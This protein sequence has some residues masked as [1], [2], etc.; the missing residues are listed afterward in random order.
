MPEAP[1][2]LADWKPYPHQ[3]KL[4]N[5]LAGGGKTAVVVWHRRAGKDMVSLRWIV[6]CCLKDPGLYWYVFPTYDQAKS[7]IWQGVTRDG[8]AYLSFLPKKYILKITQGDLTIRFKNGSILKFVGA[9]RPDTLRGVEIKG[10]VISE[11]AVCNE[12]VMSSVIMPML[13]V[14]KGWIVYLY[15]P[16]SNPELAHGRTL[17]ERL[18]TN[19]K[20]FAQLLTI[21][22]T[23]DHDGNR[24]VTKQEL[25][26]S[27]KDMEEIAREFYCDFDAWKF[28]KIENSTFGD[29]LRT[30]EHEGRITHVPYDPSLTVN[31]YWDVGIVDY[32]TIFFVQEH[33]EFLHI[34]DFYV[35]R[36][37]DFRHYIEELKLRPYKYGKN[38]LPHDMG[39]RQ[40]P[41]LD[42][43]LQGANEI[44][45]ELSL[46][47]FSLGRMYHREE[48][49]SKAREIIKICKFDV[50]KCATAIDGLKGY[51]ASERKTYTASKYATD[52][53]DAFCYLAMDAKTKIQLDKQIDIY[54]YRNRNI[55]DNYNPLSYNEDNFNPY[56]NK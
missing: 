26:D 31:T 14:S 5:Y 7:A 20:A 17:Y 50:S 11:Y 21:E 8:K 9:S 30:A 28:R 38:V 34:I 36:G 1:T 52:I 44:A 23:E 43:R 37:K 45:K 49:V 56:E 42:T 29:Q 12:K 41:K 35:N 24:F 15:T 27:G 32:T 16:S 13:A 3:R 33:K 55:L 54:A 48:M 4:W 25:L 40:M 2:F 53:A 46:E 18:K 22:D 10:A 39:R 6:A 51:N 19:P 47:P